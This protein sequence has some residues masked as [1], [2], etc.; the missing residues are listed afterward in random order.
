M[1]NE[2]LFPVGRLVGGSV[3]KGRTEDYY[4]KPLTNKDG[5]PAAEY[6]FAHAVAKRPG[7]DWKQEPWGQQMV[8]IA[9]AAFP[10][11]QPNNPSFAWKVTDG[12]SQ[13]PNKKGNKPCDNEGWPGH[14]IIWFSS[15][16][17]VKTL[18]ANGVG[19]VDPATVKPGHYIEVLGEVRVNGSTDSPGLFVNHVFVAHSAPGPEIQLGD[20]PDPTSVGFGKQALPPGAGAVPESRLAPAAPAPA[21]PAP[22]P[23]VPTVPH[24]GIL[25]PPAPPVPAAPARVMLPKAGGVSYEQFIAAGWSDA[26][27]VENGMMQA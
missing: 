17:A 11:G 7:V 22:V 2:I 12:D 1:S 5:T 27:L 6:N 10:N 9:N 16:Y 21:A 13:I 3:S 25:Q 23:T 4:G 19:A 26:Q 14:W 20:V 24:T 8:A 15:R 18:N